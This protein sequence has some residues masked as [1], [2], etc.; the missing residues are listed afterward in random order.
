MIQNQ[1]F[2]LRQ[3][4]DHAAEFEY[5]IP[6]F[7]VNTLEQAL[8][9]MRAAEAERAPAILQLTALSRQY[10]G[11]GLLPSI[12]A[13][14]ASSFPDVPVCLHLDH[15]FDLPSCA[16]AI[17]LGFNSV[18]IDGTFKSGLVEPS[19]FQDNL[20][21]TAE[22]TQFAHSKGISVE[23]ALGVVGS[24]AS[25][26]GTPEDGIE[27][28]DVLSPDLLVT[29]LDQ[30]VQF[31]EQT[32]VDALAVA[33]GTTHGLNKFH[34]EPNEGELELGILSAIHERLPN[35]HLVM[36]GCSSI[37]VELVDQINAN[38]GTLPPTWGMPIS[39]IQ[40][41]I[42]RGLRKVNIDTDNRLA[43]TAGI[44]KHLHDNPANIDPRNY[45]Q[46]GMDEVTALC[47]QRYQEFGA[48]GRAD[49]LR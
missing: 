7:N 15:G 10:L 39:L 30:A 5:A 27:T 38:G 6:A 41:A 3:L 4:L 47:R 35:T 24:L 2:G 33:V 9:I 36:H 49:L 16:S 44:R 37:P 28:T 40:F 26:V 46:A 25:C 19:D 43:M 21:L 45:L 8:A 23:G 14:L 20:H 32:K 34:H 22:V 1:S 17:S 42:K 31:V 11:D 29:D 48:S 18:M 13:G 12:F